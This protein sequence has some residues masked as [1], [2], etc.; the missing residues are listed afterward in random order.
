MFL[1][2]RFSTQ[3]RCLPISI[4]VAT[5]LLVG[6]S[7]SSDTSSVDTPTAN[8]ALILDASS[9]TPSDTPVVNEIDG[10]NINDT[11]AVQNEPLTGSPVVTDPMTQN[12]IAVNFDITVPAFQSNALRVDLVWG[13]LNLTAGWMGD[14]LWSA[15]AEFP[16]ETEEL[17]T[18]TFYDNN[19]AI[20]LAQYSQTFRT[21]SNAAQAHQISVNQFDTDQFDDDEDGVSNLEELIAGSDP[22]VDESSILEI[23]DSATISE[24]S[25]ISVSTDLESLVSQERPISFH[26]SEQL[27][28]NRTILQDIQIDLAGNGTLVSN[29]SAG[30]VYKNLSGTRTHVDN[31]ITWEATQTHDDDCD[32]IHTTNLT[33]TITVI[34]ESTRTFVEEMNARYAGTFT[35]SWQASTQITG[36]LVD[37]TSLCEAIAGTYSLTH[38]GNG[39]S[40]FSRQTLISKAIDDLYWR[41]ETE[42][43]R[44]VFNNG[45]VVSED[46]QASEYFVRELRFTN[47]TNSE[48]P[49]LFICDFVD[50]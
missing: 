34:D 7:G 45:D 18:V 24:G 50:I 16:T 41:V 3:T 1:Y 29:W 9:N 31:S 43:I 28:G 36:Q 11:E 35:D 26:F 47:N 39:N 49:N 44:T 30:C 13:D 46:V 38:R 32:F 33:N 6:C 8:D 22:T 5:A 37:G 20:E 23:R 15:S 27:E 21:G 14:E 48:N 42:S 2:K 10:L 12:T 19:G 40:Q 4:V 17:L 25:R